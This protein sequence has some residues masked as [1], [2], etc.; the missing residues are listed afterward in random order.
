[1]VKDREAPRNSLYIALIAF[2]V[3]TRV[4]LDDKDDHGTR[5]LSKVLFVA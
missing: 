5:T 1:M 2:E 4:Y 3:R